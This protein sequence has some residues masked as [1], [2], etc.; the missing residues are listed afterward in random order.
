MSSCK[1]DTHNSGFW[2][3]RCVEREE[4]EGEREKKKKGKSPVLVS[5][6]IQLVGCPGS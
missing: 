3:R 6:P 5:V 2:V 1:E 4:K